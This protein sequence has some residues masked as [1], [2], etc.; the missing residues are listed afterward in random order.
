MHC[1]GFTLRVVIPPFAINVRKPTHRVNPSQCI[2][3]KVF[4]LS[5]FEEGNALLPSKIASGDVSWL[6]HVDSKQSFKSIKN[7]VFDRLKT[8]EGVPFNAFPPL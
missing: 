8:V 1:E 4:D 6:S 3:N 5:A 7:F 2:K